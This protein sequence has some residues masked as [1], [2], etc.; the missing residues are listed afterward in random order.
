MSTMPIGRLAKA[1]GVKVPTI[2]FYEQIG[3][4][5]RPERTASDRRVYNDAALRRLSFVRHA[6]DLG[7][8]LDSI[9]SLLDLAD[10]PERPC[11]EAN[12][13]AE[14]HLAVVTGKIARL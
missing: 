7:F 9:R 1:T 11:G 12:A 3:I 2:R 14:R 4:M 8:D 6:R 5:P 10:E 13:I